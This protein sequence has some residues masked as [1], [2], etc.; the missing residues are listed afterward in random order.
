MS[1]SRMSGASPA[2]S[3]STNSLEIREMADAI[4][5]DNSHHT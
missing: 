2:K 4:D 3:P 1:L 5:S